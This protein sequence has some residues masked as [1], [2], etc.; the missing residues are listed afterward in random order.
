M[1]KI[2][3]Y[4]LCIVASGAIFTTAGAHLEH[5][6]SLKLI[7]KYKSE[8]FEQGYSKAYIDRFGVDLGT[9]LAKCTFRGG[10]TLVEKGKVFCVEEMKNGRE[11][12]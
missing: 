6:N 11:A 4:A 2:L 5:T 9:L 8:H 7:E 3:N 12:Q 1:T 10:S